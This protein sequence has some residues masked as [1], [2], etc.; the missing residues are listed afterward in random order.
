MKQNVGGLDKIIR[1]ING[2][3]PLATGVVNFRPLYALLKIS[4]ARN[5]E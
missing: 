1:T 3:I 2:L 4:T 5:K